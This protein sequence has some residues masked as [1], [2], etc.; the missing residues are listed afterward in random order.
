[1]KKHYDFAQGG[2]GVL[3]HTAVSPRLWLNY[4]WND[5]GY[6]ASFPSRGLAKAVISRP[7]CSSRK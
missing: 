6:L 2:K 5:E 1:M 7:I 4:L 3:I